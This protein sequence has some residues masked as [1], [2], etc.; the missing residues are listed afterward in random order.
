V[1]VFPA[2]C[3][4]NRRA[5]TLL[6]RGPVICRSPATVVQSAVAQVAAG[7]WCYGGQ[8]RRV[9]ERVRDD[10]DRSDRVLIFLVIVAV[11][12]AIY[13]AI[14]RARIEQANRIVEVVV[15][16]DDARLVAAA[17]GK[18]MGE[19][20]GEFREAG[21]GALAVREMTVEDLATSGR[22]MAMSTAD[23]TNL[24]TP[25]GHLAAVLATSLA[26]RLPKAKMRIASPPPVITVAMPE[27]KLADVPALLRPEDL[28]AAREA[29]LRV[30]ARLR[31]FQGATPAAIEAATAL[32][33]QAGAGLVIFDR[34]EVV[35]FDGLL[36]TTADAF[37]KQNL[38]FGYVEMAA[39]RGD[40]GLAR[41]IMPR[42]IRV[43]SI[44]EADML[45]M[46][47]AVA[48]P[49]YARAVQE[50]NIRA[51]Y[52]RLL[53]RPQPD[54]GGA[55]IAYVKAVASA[56]RAGGFTLG[57]PAPF[58][59]PEGWP[60]RW[61]RM[62]AAL[63]VIAGSVLALRRLMPLSAA[64]SWLV[65]AGLLVLGAAIGATKPDMVAPLGGVAA[66]IAFPT[67]AAVWLLQSARG[68]GPRLQI[69]SVVGRALWGLVVA[70]ATT[71]AG[72]LLIVGLYSRAGYLSGITV[73]SGVK[74]SLVAPLAL[75]FGAVVLDLP[76]QLEPLPR[77][78]AR[79]RV[80]CEQLLRQPVT[81]LLGV[82]VLVAL[83]ALAFALSR[84]GNEPVFS[85]SPIELKFR[86]LLEIVLA[87]RPR[88]K[89]FLLGHPALMLGIALARRGRRNWLPLIAVLAGL[90]QTSLL[91]TYCH[92]HSPL[93]VSLLR[94]FNGLWLGAICGIVTII[95][96]RWLFDR[97]A[98][99][100]T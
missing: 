82:V 86:H 67:L 16:A 42:V 71:F 97:R 80:R 10:M 62:I 94:M 56:I 25:D 12:A 78:W 50:R 60:P 28:D 48:V 27:D 9:D 21:A 83:G 14:G 58:S 47:P 99:T 88:T 45:T 13:L 65:F 23:E 26:A 87:I 89:E 76:M 1:L 52:V 81:V 98:P 100:E 55:N 54:P 59:A 30:V 41:R 36:K 5:A 34:D 22:V 43:H 40:I 35:G 29:G 64:L 61:A 91:N 68:T 79:V 66:A 4:G 63:G 32:A 51:V 19:L 6:R 37:T 44:T 90:G 18:S 70:S 57:P 69:A 8:V 17:S 46:T 3:F 72:A 75:A 38:L 39:Q 49:R 31:N 73:F 93:S 77:W 7:D 96:W 84:S 53:T 11:A 15:D 2:A 92:F 85:P 33:K 20:L 24:I 95:I 74:L